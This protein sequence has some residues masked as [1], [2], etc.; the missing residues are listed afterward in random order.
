MQRWFFKS[1]ALLT[2]SL[3]VGAGIHFEGVPFKKKPGKK[4]TSSAKK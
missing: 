2:V 1:F 3:V 4:S